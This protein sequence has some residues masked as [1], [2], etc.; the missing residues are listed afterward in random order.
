MARWILVLMLCAGLVAG[1]LAAA[2]STEGKLGGS[3]MKSAKKTARGW[4]PEWAKHVVW[5]QVFPDRFRN[6]D[7]S[8]DPKVESLKGS[9]PHDHTSPWEVHPWTSDWYELQPYEKKNGKDIFFNIQRRRYGGDL[10]GIR[11]K[12]DYL[13]D[14]GITAIYLNPVFEAPSLHKYD[15]I[16]YQHIDPNFGPDPEGDRKL[17]AAEKI[18]EPS[19]WVWTAADKYM[20]ELIREVHRRKMRIIFDGVF[21]HIGLAN[22]FFQDVVKNQQKSP[23][24]DW[25]IVKSWDDPGKGTK[26][27]YEGWYGVKELPEWREDEKGIVAGPKKYIFDITRRWMDPNGDGNT[28]DGID[29][30]RLDVAFC[31]KHAFWKDWCTFVRGLNPQAYMTAE[32]IEDVEANKPYLQGD[33]FTA[34][35]NYNFAFACSEYF[36]DRKIRIRTSEFDRRLRELREAYYPAVSYVMQNLVDSHDTDRIATRIVNRDRND[37]RQWKKYYEHSQARNFTYDTRKP[38]PQELK[39]QMLI[40]IFQMTYVGAPMVYYGDEAGMW[41]ANDPCCRK[42]MVWDDMSYCDEVYLPDGKKRKVPD[43]VSF[44]KDL[45]DHY[46]KLIKIRNRHE[47]LQNGDFTTLLS[48]DAKEVYAFRRSL[49]GQSLVVVLNNS[50]KAQKVTIKPGIDGRF[51]DLLNG[52]KAFST[53]KKHEITVEVPPQWGRIL[54]AEKK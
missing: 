8:N 42:P 31:V 18:E 15:T 30:W 40:A 2:A 5:Y 46:K 47:A 22:P 39:S 54:T 37:I 45:H 6:G 28:E 41:G 50:G 20:L 13:Q 52:G 34:V 23:Y 53:G 21:N 3:P 25:F 17:M 44:N 26:F 24:K 51:V 43:K 11:D 36:A 32:I 4:I 33:E 38:T 35:M 19:T 29:G 16:R 12:L 48:D 1:A 14:L 10:K 7:P 27:D 9:W 49:K